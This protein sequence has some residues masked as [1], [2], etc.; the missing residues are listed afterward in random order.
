MPNDAIM[1]V[2]DMPNVPSIINRPIPTIRPFTMP[3]IMPVLLRSESER[4]VWLASNPTAKR[5]K[6]TIAAVINNILDA[7]EIELV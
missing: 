6:K 7:R 1:G 2:I 3:L 4:C 5:F